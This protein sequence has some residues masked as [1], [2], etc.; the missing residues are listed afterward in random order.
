MIFYF[1]YCFFFGVRLVKTHELCMGVLCN[2]Y[3]EVVF[4]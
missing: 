1:V 2:F 3:F 4:A